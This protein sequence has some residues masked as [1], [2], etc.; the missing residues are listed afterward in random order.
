MQQHLFQRISAP[1]IWRTEYSQTST[2]NTHQESDI[3]PHSAQ[4]ISPVPIHQ[5]TTSISHQEIR[6]PKTH[7]K[8]NILPP[9]RRRLSPYTSRHQH[10]PRTRQHNLQQSINKHKI[11]QIIILEM[12]LDPIS[13][14]L[15]IRRHD[16]WITNDAVDGDAQIFDCAGCLAHVR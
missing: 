4:Y 7:R 14:L 6:I 13:S 16:G 11:R 10:D 12:R 1:A 3:S 2:A 9:R 5:I 8:I 15:P